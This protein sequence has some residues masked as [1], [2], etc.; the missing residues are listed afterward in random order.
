MHCERMSWIR[1]AWIFWRSRL[2]ISGSLQASL[3]SSAGRHPWKREYQHLSWT[4]RDSPR[5]VF[6]YLVLCNSGR[7]HNSQ[8]KSLDS[9]VLECLRWYEPQLDKLSTAANNDSSL[10]IRQ[11]RKFSARTSHLYVNSSFLI[12]ESYMLCLASMNGQLIY[13]WTSPSS[14]DRLTNHRLYWYGLGWLP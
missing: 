5:N 13:S 8:W 1:W 4:H 7:P 3:Q 14:F 6:W 12:S 9:Y 2:S 11:S 10:G